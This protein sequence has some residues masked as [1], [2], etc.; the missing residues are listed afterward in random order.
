MIGLK[1]V[2]QLSEFAVDEPQLA[3]SAYTKAVL[4]RWGFLQRTIP[5]TKQYFLPLEAAIRDKLIP[6]IIGRTVSDLERNI[7]SLPVRLGGM[8][9]QNPT[10]TADIEFRNS[11]I[12]TRNLTELIIRQETNLTSYNGDRMKLELQK[13]RAE[14]E[15]AMIAQME[16]LKNQADPQ[17]NLRSMIMV[18]SSL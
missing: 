2:E 7:M 9:I 18:L 16:E 3:Y 11:S 10:Y 6:A 1:D 14:K 12:V 13:L 5:N 8:G 17:T 15:Q 4:M